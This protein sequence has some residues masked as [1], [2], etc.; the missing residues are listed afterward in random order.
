[1]NRDL[2]RKAWRISDLGLAYRHHLSWKSLRLLCC[3][4][5]S[6]CSLTYSIGSSYIEASSS[7][8]STMSTVH[9]PRDRRTR[10]TPL[11]IGRTTSEF[12][13][14]C[15]STPTARAATRREAPPTRA[16]S[17]RLLTCLPQNGRGSLY[18]NR[19]HYTQHKSQG[20]S[21]TVF[22]SFERILSSALRLP[23]LFRWPEGNASRPSWI[24][25]AHTLPDR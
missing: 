7:V 12:G 14:P 20:H 15:V 17:A 2:S 10:S 3:L 25:A 13:R 22:G 9:L 4:T 16:I 1:M 23:Q 19:E 21:L 6:T 24:F 5:G 11:A 8:I 18:D